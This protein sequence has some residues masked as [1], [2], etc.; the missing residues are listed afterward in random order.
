VTHDFTR[1]FYGSLD[2]LYRRGFESE[3]NGVRVPGELDVGNIGLTLNYQVSNNLVIR[4]G[5]SSNVFGDG[6]LDNS[7]LRIQFVYGWHRLMENLK[8]LRGQK[9]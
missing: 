6:A 8:K 3:I 1:T 2:L 5:Y 9:H 7:L 4:T